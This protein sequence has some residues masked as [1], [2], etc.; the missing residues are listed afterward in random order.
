MAESEGL[1]KV[2]MEFEG[3]SDPTGERFWA[4][5]LGDG[6]YEIRNTPWFAFDLN[7]G[8]V[9]RCQEFENE[10]PVI[11]Q[12]VRRGGHKTLRVVF[13]EKES[14]ESREKI[15]EDLGKLGTNHEHAWG[16]LYSIDVPP[17][18]DYQAVCDFLWGL[19]GE[20]VLAYETGA[21]SQETLR[22]MES[23]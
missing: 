14:G 9:V 6:L 18:T 19:E 2:R 7:W 4:L 22:Q 17:G 12:V 13:N 3:H 20:D 23:D 5:P 15:L 1:V 21:S 11:L 16:N 8:D 10:V